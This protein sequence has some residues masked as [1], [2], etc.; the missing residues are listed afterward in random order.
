MS[1]SYNNLSTTT[2]ASMEVH[3][4]AFSVLLNKPESDEAERRNDDECQIVLNKSYDFDVSHFEIG[5][6][7]AFTMR[8]NIIV[9]Q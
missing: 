4:T 2:A 6:N 5:V 1:H 7:N 3:A 8:K 9:M